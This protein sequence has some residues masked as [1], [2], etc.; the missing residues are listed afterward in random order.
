MVICFLYGSCDRRKNLISL[1]YFIMFD[2]LAFVDIETTGGRVNYD[3]IIEIGIVRVENG[4]I[5]KTYSTL[6]NP[7]TYLSPFIAQMTGISSQ[8]LE[9]APLFEDIIET[10][11]ETLSD[12]I[13]VAHNVRFD[14]G[15]IRNEFRR[16]GYTYSSKHFCTAKLS[17]TLFPQ[18][19]HH[20]LDSIMERF[21]LRCEH[22]H[23]AL[24]DAKVTFEFF[25]G[26]V[27][28]FSE[29]TVNSVL[30]MIVK[31]PSIP[32][33][34]PQKQVESLPTTP[35]VY[36]FYGDD[37]LPLY[38]G[39]SVNIRDRVFSHFNEDYNS[40]RE[41]SIC[42]QMKSIEAIQTAGE[43]GALFKESMLIKEMQPIYNRQLRIKKRMLIGFLDS[44]KNGYYRIDLQEVDFIDP[45]N[46][47][48]VLG[49]F[50]SRKQ[51]REHMRAMVKEF[52][53]CEKLLDIEKGS[54]PCFSYKLQ[55]CKGACCGK[56]TPEEYNERF[57]RAF[58]DT[59]IEPW[60]FEGAIAIE[61]RDERTHLR[62]TFVVDKWC[63]VGNYTADGEGGENIVTRD[64]EFDLDTYKILSRFVKSPKAVY[65]I[66]P[67]KQN[68]QQTES[69]Y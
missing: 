42:Q 24:D 16:H 23:R 50:K 26:A 34:L 5:A 36:I 14:Y 10:V 15:F 12:C 39:K 30:K 51:A 61:E 8:E 67:L 64:R 28:R 48:R 27:N 32:S 49:V 66:K 55:W 43:L 29:D 69:L 22:R 56:E 41:M 53:L 65:K 45:E 11:Q 21:N 59:R 37:G 13:F 6:L 40:S 17:R 25:K 2:K 54:G 52:G 20:N 18:H 47:D 4:E 19:R 33:G 3:R 1:G 58:E 68:Y 9:K 57:M 63:L 35:G 38:I 44:D 7:E 60:P 46:I 62:Q 31:K